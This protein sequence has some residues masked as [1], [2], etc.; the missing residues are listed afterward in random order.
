M[1]S[2]DLRIHVLTADTH[3]NAADACRGLPCGLVILPEGD[4]DVAKWD[5][6]RSLGANQTV[7]IGNGRND[8]LMVGEAAI[9]IAVIGEE[10]S[11]AETVAAAQIVCRSVAEALSLLRHP[12]RLVATLRT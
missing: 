9:G 2:R 3:G 1:L 11:S 10:G 12:K 8:R 5:Y 7:S 6:G 4:Q